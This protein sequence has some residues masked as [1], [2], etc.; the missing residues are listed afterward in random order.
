MVLARTRQNNP[1][2]S[3]FDDLSNIWR[4]LLSENATHSPKNIRNGRR[5]AARVCVPTSERAK[6][7][8]RVVRTRRDLARSLHKLLSEKSFTR[9]SIQE[10]AQRA[11]INRATFYAHFED[12]YH[13][14]QYMFC[15]LFEERV[16][17]RVRFCDGLTPKNLEMLTAA[18]CELL[19]EF[20]DIYASK[21]IDEHPPVE[22]LVQPMILEILTAWVGLS[23]ADV[24]NAVSA[25]TV[26]NTLS[27]AMFG[28][29]LQWSRGARAKSAETESQQIVTLLLSGLRLQ[30]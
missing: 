1:Q 15:G 6:L 20:N 21:H 27:W 26:A 13:L 18:T 22:R 17:P 29:A 25:E 12:K 4:N 24:G 10:I 2:W 19:A 8:P 23:D 9:I 30:A 16:I 5:T 3:D 28:S 14:L 7:D 11:L